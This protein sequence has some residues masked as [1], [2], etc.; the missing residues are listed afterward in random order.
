MAWCHIWTDIGSSSV[1][2]IDILL[3]EI[4]QEIPSIS[5]F[6]YIWKIHINA[7]N[8]IPTIQYAFKVIWLENHIEEDVSLWMNGLV[9]IL[10]IWKA[11]RH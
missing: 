5:V 4:L 10:V 3:R 2:F 8:I 11:S 7:R 1:R 6:D 9:A